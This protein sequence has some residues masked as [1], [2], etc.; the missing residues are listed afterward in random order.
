VAAGMEN[1]AIVDVQLSIAVANHLLNRKRR[2]LSELEHETRRTIL[3]RGIEGFAV[4][5]VRYSCT[6]R[7][8]REIPF[9]DVHAVQPVTGPA[10]SRPGANRG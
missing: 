1:V 6:D 5:E 8:G 2:I 4:D 9:S 3:V 7:R 10:E